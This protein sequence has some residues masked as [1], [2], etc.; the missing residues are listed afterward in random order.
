VSLGLGLAL[1]G[2]LTAQARADFMWTGGGSSSAWSDGAN[3]QGGTAPTPG[4]AVGTLD[5]PALPGLS[6]ASNDLSGL[7]A[8]SLQIDDSHGYTLN[9]QGFGLGGP[10]GLSIFATEGTA[11]SLNLTAPISLEG[12]QVW[13]ITSPTS[14]SQPV[15]IQGAIS[16]SSALTIEVPFSGT[17]FS[18]GPYLTD[19]PITTDDE[20]GD[21]K[22]EGL[23]SLSSGHVYLY[24]N[25]NQSDGHSVTVEGL[26]FL[27]F[28]ST[29]P[30]HLV[31]S[32]AQ[33]KGPS[34]GALSTT[35]SFVDPGGQLSVASASLDEASTIYF[36]VDGH[37]SIPGTD[38]TKVSSTGPVALGNATLALEGEGPSLATE[39][40]PPTAGLAYPIISTTGTLSGSFKN[41]PDGGTITTS[42]CVGAGPDGFVTGGPYTYRINYNRTSSPRTVTATALPSETAKP[43]E[44]QPKES[45]PPAEPPH[46]EPKGHSEP[47]PLV[48]GG[49]GGAIP[50]VPASITTAQLATLIRQQLVPHGTAASLGSLLKHGSLTMPFQASAAGTLSVG[51]YL[52]PKGATLTKQSKPVLVAS[53]KL[54]VA[55]GVTGQ[56]KLK[57]TGEG[58]QRLK[59]AKRVKLTAK[60]SFASSGGVAVS[61]TASVMLSAGAR[62]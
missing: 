1:L 2:C 10:F 52:V 29:G 6:T 62:A 55:A 12:D 31:E 45:T 48:T 47:P 39:C 3:W 11:G 37:G 16:G 8:S 38:F 19:G 13:E 32:L 5:F 22:L 59:H 24:A 54:S 44:P 43:E 58:K 25:L 36:H 28:G 41:A 35:G 53:G 56:V 40:P 51:W 14:I 42:E 20:V 50:A 18:L 34:T 9:G 26:Q 15:Q 46:E 61:A 23:S 17:Q 7:K 30:L 57:L 33:L 49:G 21:V 60:A 4:S 27:D